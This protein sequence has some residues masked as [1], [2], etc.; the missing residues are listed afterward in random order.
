MRELARHWSLDP[1]VVFLNHGS[2]GA[3]PTAVLEHQFE[4][5]RRLERQPLDFLAREL[6]DR[7]DGARAALASFMD[8]DAQDLAFVP[9]A[10]TGVNSVLRSMELS[11]DDDVL[12]TSHAYNA[13]RNALDFVA[14]RAGARVVVAEIPF[15]I[16]DPTVA[17]EAILS[18][19]TDR[20][21]IA[22]VD[23]IT[24][25]TGL[26]LPIA[27]I[28]DGL[29]ERG[30]LSL[31]DAA[32]APGH[33][34][35]SLSAL[36]PDFYTGNCHKW[37][38]TP[39]GSA[40]LYVR[41]ELQS[42]VRPTVISHGANAERSD[43]SRFLLEFDWTGT[44]DPTP[45]LCIPKALEFVGSLLEGGWPEIIE[46]NHRLALYGRQKLLDALGIEAPAPEAMIANLVTV[47]LPEAAESPPPG[48]V[49]FD[50]LQD[51][52]RREHA[53]EVPVFPWPCPPGRALRISAHLYNDESQYDRLAE[54]LQ[55]TLAQ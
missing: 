13:C 4:L 34:P 22:L 32:H 49:P 55:R 25:S 47:P 51:T 52:L 12:V 48:P 35:V 33:V 18:A 29:R 41:R 3:C 26:L 50:A 43:R 53:I 37:L 15:P 14:A 19:V 17:T 16:A 45:Y 54:A 27:D 11:S 42:W 38:C 10:T 44:H 9:N 23:H 40:L 31:V 24:S 6:E 36:D 7:I 46:H 2:F 28:L 39:K 20:T 8:C 21:R 30:V 1:D 5:L